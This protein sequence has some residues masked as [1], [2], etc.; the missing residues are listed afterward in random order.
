MIL[1]T[2]AFASGRLSA[3]LKEF[4][5]D[6]KSVFDLNSNDIST[7][8]EE[9]IIYHAEKLAEHFS[10]SAEKLTDTFQE[11]IVITS[12]VGSGLVPIEKSDRIYRESVGRMNVI[13]AENAEEVYRVCCGIMVKI[14]G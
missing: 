1:V 12:E 4:G 7:L 3:V 13:L 14:K 11:K 5:L 8:K 6:E 10:A 2:G 9:K